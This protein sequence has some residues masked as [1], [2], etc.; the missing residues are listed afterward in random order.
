MN[1][2]LLRQE[3]SKSFENLLANEKSARGFF[4]PMFC[5]GCPRGM[6]V[7]QYLF[8]GFGRPDR[9]FDRMSAK[10]SGQTLPLW[11]DFLFVYFRKD[12]DGPIT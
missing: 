6:S 3:L 1:L 2:C 7:P 8:P 9:S 10:V 11:A 12:S 5:N 4:R